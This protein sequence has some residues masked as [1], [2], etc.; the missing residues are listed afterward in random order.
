MGKE[1]GSEADLHVMLPIQEAVC[2]LVDGT[3]G[4]KGRC[5]IIP[6]VVPDIAYNLP[7]SS[8]RVSPSGVIAVP[9]SLLFHRLQESSS[10]SLPWLVV[11][12]V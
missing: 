1:I 9:I 3:A 5:S 7:R 6:A 4:R 11:R 2:D 8:H 10:A 12:L